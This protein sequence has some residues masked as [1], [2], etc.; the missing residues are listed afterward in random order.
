V[1]RMIRLAAAGV[2][3]SLAVLPTLAAAQNPNGPPPG[4]GRGMGPNQQLGRLV[5][6]QLGLS[7]S[8]VSRLQESDR[9][10]GERL[11]ALNDDERQSRQALREILCSGDTTR[12]GDVARLLDQLS[13]SQR[14][15]LQLYEEEQRDLATFLTPYQRARFVGIREQLQMR[16]DPG[17]RGG[18]GRGPGGR[19][20]P[21]PGGR[22][23]APEQPDPCVLG[24]RGARR[25]G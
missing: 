19:M 22:Q 13:D 14:Q 24:A 4:R 8:Q 11:R 1:R 2:V 15:R 3:A 5:A 9:R 6:Q 16:L 23:G 21:R 17:V 10:F 18:G 20:G 12:A 7:D 25:G